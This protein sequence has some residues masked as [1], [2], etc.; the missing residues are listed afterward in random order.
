[1]AGQRE[2]DARASEARASYF[3]RVD[4]VEAWQRGNNPVFVFG[5]LLSQ[6]RFTMAN[7]ALDALNHPDPLTNYHA[8]FSVDQ[9][10]Y[11][12]ARISGIKSAGLGQQMAAASLAE[13]RADLALA[14]TRAYGDALQATA[15][16]DG[17][18]R[19]GRRGEGGPGARRT[20]PRRRDGVGG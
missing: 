11:D 14:T 7:F 8:A 3:P 4:F 9:P 10:I 17:C 13:A 12:S 20:Q 2:S 15:N 19:S 1:M 16:R 5:S 18:R 6:Q